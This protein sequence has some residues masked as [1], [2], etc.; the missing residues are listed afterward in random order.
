MANK[1]PLLQQIAQGYSPL[2]IDLQSAD[3]FQ[4]S[5]EYMGVLMSK[6]PYQVGR[7]A[8]GYAYID[9]AIQRGMADPS[10]NA[11]A[12]MIDSPGG[13]VTEC[14]ELSDKIYAARGQKPMRAFAANHAYSAAYSIA[15]AADSI[16]I[17][18]SGGVGSIGVVT[19]HMDVSAALEKAGVKITFI[20]AGAHK[21]D[22]NPY[23]KLPDAVKSRI[24]DRINKT[25]SVFTSS[26]A[27]NRAMD[28]K[29]VRA[30]EA[31]CYD[32]ED[33]I[34]E[35]LADKVGALDDELVLFANGNELIEEENMATDIITP[36]AHAAALADATAAGHKAGLVEGTAAGE[37]NAKARIV[38]ILGSD[39]AKGR[40][41]AA[42]A[43]ALDTDMPVDQATSFIGKL[44]EEKAEPVVATRK[45]GMSAFEAAMLKDNPDLG[46]GEG[47]DDEEVEDSAKAAKSILGSFAQA[48]GL[49]PRKVA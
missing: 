18:R 36:E 48:S 30:T 25:Y 38:A 8:T 10:V 15:S 35:G 13:E 7:W 41:A 39:Q 2:L 46:A 32:A 14:F 29:A 22:G 27:R 47:V 26:V 49:K 19:S 5:I 1:M 34:T 28:E 16:T 12:F 43:A 20:I 44:A 9:K 23:E 17:T 24:Q 45:T 33:A 37:A 4:A 21:V 11:I 42:L 31:L 3:L 6:F 40:P